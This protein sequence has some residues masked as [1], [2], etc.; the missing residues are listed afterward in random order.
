MRH[1]LMTTPGTARRV[2]GVSGRGTGAEGGGEQQGPAAGGRGA[3]AAS[4]RNGNL[5]EQQLTYLFIVS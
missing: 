2:A 5:F 1:C 3:L 4:A